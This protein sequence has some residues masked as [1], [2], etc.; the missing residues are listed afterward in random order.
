MQQLGSSSIKALGNVRGQKR[1]AIQSGK[2]SSGGAVS[3]RCSIAAKRMA[4]VKS[5]TKQIEIG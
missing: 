2:R 1:L 3:A 5:G 4:L